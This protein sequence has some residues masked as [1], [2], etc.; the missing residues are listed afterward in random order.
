MC[1]GTSTTTQ[2]QTSTTSANPLTQ[3]AVEQLLPQAVNVAQTPY[4]QN[5]NANVA[6]L[7]PQQQ[8]AIQAQGGLLSNNPASSYINQSNQY[9]QQAADPNSVIAMQQQFYN[10]MASQVMSQLQN[11]FGQ[12]NA[13]LLGNQAASGAIGGSRSGVADA[14]LA[15]S[16]TLAAGQTLAGLQQQALGA[17]QT[18]QGQIAGQAYQQGQLGQEALNSQISAINQALQGGQLTYAEAQAQLNAIQQNSIAKTLFPQQELA[19]AANIEAGLG[20][21]LGGTTTG[22]SQ[23]TQPVNYLGQIIGGLSAGLGALKS[24][25]RAKENIRDIGKTHDGQRIYSFQYKGDPTVRIGMMAG[26][27]AK[28]HPEAVHTDSQGIRYVDYGKATED[29]AQMKRAIGGGVGI[30]NGLSGLQGYSGLGHN[31][32][33]GIQ[34]YFGQPP[35]RREDGGSVGEDSQTPGMDLYRR[36]PHPAPGDTTPGMDLYRKAQE[37]PRP[38]GEDIVRRTLE[39]ARGNPSPG[40]DLYRR[41]PHRPFGGRV[42]MQDGGDPDAQDVTA[43]QDGEGV[44]SRFINRRLNDRDFGSLPLATDYDPNTPAQEQ[45][46]SLS[47]APVQQADPQA[48]PASMGS[49]AQ[50]PAGICYQGLSQPQSVAQ[51]G[52]DSLR[53]LGWS[54]SAIRGALANGNPES[55]FNPGQRHWDQPNPV[56]AGTEAANAH[57][58]F[59][60]GGAEY[61]NYANW[62]QKNGFSNDQ[63]SDPVLQYRFMDWN[64]R[65]RYPQVFDAMQK[66]TPEQ[67]G[68]AFLSGYLKPRSDY[69]AQRSD[70]IEKGVPTTEDLVKSAGQGGI[71]QGTVNQLLQ[72]PKE[73]SYL[74]KT[75]KAFGINLDQPQGLGGSLGRMLGMQPSFDQ[76]TSDRLVNMGLGMLAS[77]PSVGVKGA[78]GAIVSALTSAGKGG[79]YMNQQD[80]ADKQAA[81]NLANAAQN[82]QLHEAQIAHLKYEMAKPE[83][84][85]TDMNYDQFGIPHP[86]NRMGVRDPNSPTG[87]RE[88]QLPEQA[89]PAQAAKDAQN[90]EELQKSVPPVVWEQAQAVADYD[91]APYTGRQAN[92]GMGVAVMA[93]ARKIAQ[94]RGEEYNEGVYQSKVAA[95]KALTASVD[96]RTLT[97]GN[98]GIDHLRDLVESVDKM[99]P[100]QYPTL[101][102]FS[103]WLKTQAGKDATKSYNANAGLLAEELT[104]FYRGIGGAEADI[105]RH[106]TDLD[107]DSSLEQ[108]RGVIR[109]VAEMVR[110]KVSSLETKR[111]YAF[112]KNGEQK[113]PILNAKAKRDL[114]AIEEWAKRDPKDRSHINAQPQQAAPAAA[115][116]VPV[117]TIEDAMK[118]PSGTPFVTPDGRVKVRP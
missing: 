38:S 18:Q 60:L 88:I 54:D 47:P 97:N 108:Q 2:N 74:D 84:I 24:D 81:I 4:D 50:A 79:L 51:M 93:T 87:Y 49:P 9:S 20:P 17:A 26:Q 27:V 96:S 58:V 95:Q 82:Q 13:Q 1:G 23:T 59:S 7:N 48:Q 29:A 98:T 94:L 42:H 52:V 15:N 57:G 90:I 10:P 56:F 55:G 44:A 19:T 70:Q 118:L 40:E 31:N 28:K 14:N 16:Q 99:D 68:Q 33:G 75:L 89:Q 107:P 104:S 102:H 115:Q 34:P 22:T 41:T 100:G 67:A 73:P 64:L 63:W 45:V 12:Q 30:G 5:M 112:G 39:Q 117:N 46:L 113:F 111:D 66:G 69:L 36:T 91:K 65:T 105:K 101:N 76:Q 53:N 92:Q 80:A 62:L 71:S 110:D 114:D 78:P 32:M 6:N 109:K 116:P 3:Q 11:V 61:N 83:V 43:D 37:A 106:L 72:Q 21:Q 8:A 86:R 85:G 25:E 77:G 35:K 103:N